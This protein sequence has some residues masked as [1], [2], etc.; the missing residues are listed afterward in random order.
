M[1]ELPGGT[2]TLVFTDIEG[3]TRLLEALAEQY[4]KVLAEH[5][6]LLR[7]AFSSSGGV[8]VDTQG[9]A[10]FYA[11]SRATDAVVAAVE[12]QRA[13][14]SHPWAQG[15]SV[16]VRMGIHS[17]EPALS[18]EGYVGADVH[19]AARICSAA[20]GGQVLVSEATARLVGDGVGE[21]E[22]RDLGV[23]GLKD[24]SSPQ[25]LYQLVI[26]GLRQDFPAI[27]TLQGRPNNL[28]RQLTPLLGRERE[29]AQGY[30]LLEGDAALVSLTGPGGTGKT[31]LAL[32]IGAE[33]LDA[34][35]DG[36]FFV[37]LSAVTEPS[38]VIPAVAQALSLR[39]SGG[40]T[41]SVTLTDYLADKEMLVILD[42]FEQVIEAASEVSSLLASGRGLKVVVTTR[43]PLRVRGERELAVPPLGLPSPSKE[44]DI[45]VV[46][47]SAAVAL[48][49]ARA[50]G[51]KASFELTSDN[52]SSVAKICRRLD[53][54]PLA[55]E[56]AA[57]RIKALSPSSLLDRLDQSLKVLTGGARDASSRQRTLRGAI[58][59]SHKLLS[60]DEQ[61]LFRRL[62]VFAGG[63]SLETAETVCDQ[64]DLQLEILD[65]ISSLVEKSL[66]RVAVA[67]DEER[68]SMLETIRE[69]ATERLEE[70][71]DAREIRRA[72]AEC[73]RGLAEEAEPQLVGA[74]QR[75]WLARLETEHDNL[76][77]ALSWSVAEAPALALAVAAA[78]WRF[79]YVRGHLTEGRQWLE[80]VTAPTSAKT[81][82]LLA[83]ALRGLAVSLEVQGEYGRSE[84]V[85]QQSLAIYEQLGDEFGLSN[86]LETLA[87]AAENQGNF[88]LARSRY[89]RALELSERIGDVRGATWVGNNLADLLLRQGDYETAKLRLQANIRVLAEL[90]DKEGLAFAL[91]N[92]SQALL[93]QRNYKESLKA[94]RES[95]ILAEEFGDST[96]VAYCF[97]LFAAIQSAQGKASLAARSLG[98][99]ENLLDTT[100]IQLNP[101]EKL[102]HEDTTQRTLSE[103]SHDEFV[104]GVREGRAL[105]LDLAIA[106]ALTRNL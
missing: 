67:G 7:E 86:I 104:A 46:G 41:I 82:P 61:R 23:H 99:A 13:L 66:V 8:E 95:L 90:G 101:A 19:R 17:G 93:G 39:E 52:A 11:F 63:W 79:W 43:E 25:H 73:F 50:R 29:I 102:I 81:Q 96:I 26:E 70:S 92:M 30:R 36:A 100:G 64:D 35:T 42:N 47:A 65:G 58:E 15:V 72:H 74:D 34:F 33:L 6:K 62:G 24:L 98:V 76:R 40:K 48:F 103:L 56:L 32:A 69:F 21:V 3:S 5:R 38:L 28:P 106:E 54:L 2:V 75:E 9:D 12:A 45:E 71:G 97:E 55:I 1:A 60:Q 87:I 85:A 83:K 57:A 44:S 78:M 20:H 84:H 59:W 14:A 68:F 10:L 88:D 27:R 31:R 53:G 77:G 105:P 91:L 94:A 37:D 51:V 80:A 18:E 22:L 49:V 4:G 16:A 89:E